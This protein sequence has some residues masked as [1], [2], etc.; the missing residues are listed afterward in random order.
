[1]IVTTFA[2]T[3]D[4]TTTSPSQPNLVGAP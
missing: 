1:M 3:L 4:L 2:A